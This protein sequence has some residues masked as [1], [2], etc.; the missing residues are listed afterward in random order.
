MEEHCL[1]RVVLENVGITDSVAYIYV[2][3][4]TTREIYV[5]K[6]KIVNNFVHEHAQYLTP[7]PLDPITTHTT[8]TKNKC[9][10]LLVVGLPSCYHSSYSGHHDDKNNN[11]S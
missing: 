2:H 7:L 11:M 8:H 9:R 4:H 10:L 3:L 6:E 5:S 1:D